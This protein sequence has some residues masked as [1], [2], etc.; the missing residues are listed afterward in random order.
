M[1][2][3]E[4]LEK[5]YNMKKDI[6]V[7]LTNNKINDFNNKLEI[8]FDDQYYSKNFAIFENNKKILIGHYDI[9]GYSKNNKWVWGFENKY[10]EKYLTEKSKKIYDKITFRED[11]INNLLK[12]CLYF[13][14]DIWI[15]KRDISNNSKIPMYEYILLTEINQIT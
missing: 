13:S 14:N 7:K 6:I 8:F 15:I 11:D 1:N 9:L 12:L 5:Y 4:K 10:V 2:F 3:E